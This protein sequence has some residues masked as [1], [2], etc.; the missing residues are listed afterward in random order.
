MILFLIIIRESSIQYRI[1]ELDLDA[2][3]EGANVVIVHE[4]NA[5]E[6]VYRI[7]QHRKVHSGY[8][9]FSMT[10]IIVQSVILSMKNTI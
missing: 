10:L 5:H 9:L 3:L 8:R 2:V 7:G 6:L 4:W 1:E